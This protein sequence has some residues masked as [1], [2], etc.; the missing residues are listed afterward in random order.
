M[1]L[2]LKKETVFKVIA[3]TAVMGSLLGNCQLP[4]PLGQQAQRAPVPVNAG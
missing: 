3:A 4:S 1:K 2:M